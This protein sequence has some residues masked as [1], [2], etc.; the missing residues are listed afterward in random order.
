L[1]VARTHRLPGHRLELEITEVVLMQNTEATFKT[2]HQLPSLG[3]RIS[4]DDFGTGY[5]S[6]SYL[7]SFPFDKIKVD[8]RFIKGLP[9]NPTR[10]STR[11]RTLR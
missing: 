9:P 2:L 1:H 5:S 11:W 10:F 8:R 4:I 3:I 7:R 6:F